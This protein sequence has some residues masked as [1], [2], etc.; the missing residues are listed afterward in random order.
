[1]D[2]VIAAIKK[3]SMPSIISGTLVF[4]T[5]VVILVTNYSITQLINDTVGSNPVS[6]SARY[7]IPLMGGYIAHLYESIVAGLGTMTYTIEAVGISLVLAGVVYVLLRIGSNFTADLA[8]KWTLMHASPR[9]TIVELL[10]IVAIRLSL[11]AITAAYAWF[12]Y[13]TILPWSTESF[14]RGWQVFPDPQS[15]LDIGIMSITLLVLSLHLF[16]V[17][18]RLILMRPRLLS[19]TYS[20]S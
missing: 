8:E 6:D 7:T 18:A 1:M 14:I 16:I 10:E 2:S 15:L 19:A 4:I 20:Q 13:D 9:S 5:T 17:L 12:W 3:W 11:V